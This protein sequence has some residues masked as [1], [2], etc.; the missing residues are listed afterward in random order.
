MP[1]APRPATA[2]VIA[3]PPLIYGV[4]LLM[5]LLL[6]RWVP[7]PLVAERLTLPLGLVLV[8]LG[9]VALPAILAFR[10]ARTHPEPWKP[11]KALVTVGPYRYSRNP[12][13]VGMA[14]LYLGTAIWQNT[15]WPLLALPAVIAVIHVGVIRREERYLE[16][17]FG[18]DYRA[19]RERVRRWL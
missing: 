4:P 10:V 18:E 3:P 16:A 12:M 11:T 9:F 5:G 15:V 17:L 2:G 8:T 6:D 14:L 13:Y 1:D 7:W 19:Y